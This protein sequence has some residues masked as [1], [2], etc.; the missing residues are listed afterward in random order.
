[1][2]QQSEN[3]AQQALADR[4]HRRR[5]LKQGTI[6]YADGAISVHCLVRD[7]TE[8]GAKLRLQSPEPV[9]N[10]FNLFIPIDGLSKSCVIRWRENDY[11]GVEFTEDAKAISGRRE[12][13]VVEAERD[14]SLRKRIV[15]P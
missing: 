4:E 11:V 5:A 3:S 6:S 13:V 9:P 14:V 15:R 7:Q 8:K 12:Q 1:M 10:T 2:L